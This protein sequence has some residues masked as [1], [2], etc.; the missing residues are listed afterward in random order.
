MPRIIPA[1]IPIPAP[2]PSAIP[3]TLVMTT[4]KNNPPTPTPPTMPL[5]IQPLSFSSFYSP[6]LI[7]ILTQ[8]HDINFSFVH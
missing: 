6:L 2:N 1:I 5:Y 3:I 4:P 7:V 8:Y